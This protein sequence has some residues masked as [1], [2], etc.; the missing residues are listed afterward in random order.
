MKR[1]CA[2][3]RIKIESP[4]KGPYDTSEFT[5]ADISKRFALPH[6]SLE[7]GAPAPLPPTNFGVLAVWITRQQ[8]P[9]HIWEGQEARLRTSCVK[10]LLSLFP[11]DGP[12]RLLNGGIPGG[13]GTPGRLYIYSDSKEEITP[14]NIGDD[15]PGNADA[16]TLTVVQ[17]EHFNSGKM[18]M[19]DIEAEKVLWFYPVSTD[20]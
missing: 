1:S 19:V 13:E 8:P 2:L 20:R 6:V 11:G 9:P 18:V 17:G 12:F 7:W 16:Y 10:L 4:K 5:D 3:T 14:V 15:G